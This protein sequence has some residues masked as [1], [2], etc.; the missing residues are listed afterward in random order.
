[1]GLEHVIVGA[2]LN[3]QQCFMT[4]VYK[5]QAFGGGDDIWAPLSS[6]FL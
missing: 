4:L 2:Q 3:P 1:M 5:M 6:V